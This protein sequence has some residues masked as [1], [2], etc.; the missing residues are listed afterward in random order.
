[1][2]FDDDQKQELMANL[3]RD[4]AE[5]LLEGLLKARAEAEADTERL[6]QLTP[7][8]LAQG[9]EAM[10]HAI[11]SARRMV[12]ALNEALRIAREDN[13]QGRE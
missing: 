8:Q 13:G 5:A 12:Q 3:I 7:E 11:A 4:K 6:A 1:M 10:D 9:R 2:P